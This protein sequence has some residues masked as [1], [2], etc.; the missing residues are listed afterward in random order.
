MVRLVRS[1]AL[2]ACVALSGCLETTP[3]DTLGTVSVEIDGVVYAT[4]V[5]NVDGSTSP[6]QPLAGVTVSTTLDATSVESDANGRFHLAVE[7]TPSQGE[8][9]RYVITATAPGL[10]PCSV[11]ENWGPRPSDVVVVMKGKPAAGNPTGACYI[12]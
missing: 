1:G 7:N 5:I 6:T 2:C 8:T 3:I 4:D 10:T 11:L 9:L 12:R